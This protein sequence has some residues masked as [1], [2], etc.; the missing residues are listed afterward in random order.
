MKCKACG[1]QNYEVVSQ[2]LQTKKSG[3]GFVMFFIIL[4]CLGIILS[5]T[6]ILA[7]A[8]SSKRSEI[9]T[10][11]IAFLGT[12]TFFDLLKTSITL[13]VF[14]ELILCV[15]PYKTKSV[16]TCVCKDCGK[17]WDISERKK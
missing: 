2:T 3:K 9:E 11:I 8:L 16:I 14:S 17:V 12:F 10:A 15:L 13:L 4:A 1:S 7:P 5:L 6:F